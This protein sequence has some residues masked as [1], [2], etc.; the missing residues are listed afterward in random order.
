MAQEDTPGA[1]QPGVK[2]LREKLTRSEEE[3]VELKRQATQQAEEL[4]KEKQHYNQLHAML[5]EGREVQRDLEQQLGQ[6]ADRMRQMQSEGE[7]LMLRAVAEETR[8]WKEREA[9]WVQR[10]RA[11]ES[12]E[13]SPTAM[14][15]A[16]DSATGL[17]YVASSRNVAS[18]S[19][20]GQQKR[21]SFEDSNEGVDSVGV[22][23]TPSNAGG[24]PQAD[25]DRPTS[26]V[27]S[28]NSPQ[29]CAEPAPVH[30][31][32]Q[33]LSVHSPTFVPSWGW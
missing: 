11:L 33:R 17:G 14:A 10:L 16:S 20:C 15:S 1:V 31:C 13:A 19:R 28:T 27:V 32:P 12:K 3:A 23:T 4:G 7:L 25:K 26:G 30:S 18:G 9:Q 5:E 8:K 6:A 29:H 22:G 24:D 2:E 21:V